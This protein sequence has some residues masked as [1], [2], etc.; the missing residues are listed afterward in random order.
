MKSEKSATASTK[1]NAAIVGLVLLGAAG[2]IASVEGHDAESLAK[3]EQHAITVQGKFYCNT[4]ALTS[5]E[6]A[7]HQELTDKLMSV[8]KETVETEKGYEFQFSP[9]EVR[10]VNWRSGLPRR[11]SAARSSIFISTWNARAPC[12]VCD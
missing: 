11:A 12:C 8:R 9:A 7:R 4:K 6:R 3:A 2:A 10:S 5:A 1:G